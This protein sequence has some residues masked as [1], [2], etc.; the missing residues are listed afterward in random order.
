M[1]PATRAPAEGRRLRIA[2][3]L[4]ALDVGGTEN[5]TVNVINGLAGDFDHAIVTM[6][7]EGRLAA[8]LP[9]GVPVLRVVK[10]PGND[11][12][13]V[14]GLV[15]TLRALRPD[16]VHSRNWGAFDAVLAARLAGVRAVVHGE[17]GREATD[18]DGQNRRRRVLRRWLSPLISRYVTVSDDLRRWLLAQVGIAA[19]K[20]VTIPNGVDTVR[21][22]P[23]DQDGARAALGLAP[24]QR[25]V[26]TVG[27]LDPVKDQAGLI[28]AFAAVR[29]EQPGACLVIA[30]DGPCASALRALVER[31]GLGGAV[32]LLGER[33]DIPRVLAA[34]DVFVLPSIAEGMSNTVLEA[35]ATGLPVVATRVGANPE[36]V[37]DGVTGTLVPARAP[38]ALAH[39]IARYVADPLLCQLHGKASRQRV[40]AQFTLARMC[41]GYRQLY[42]DVTGAA[43]R[44][45]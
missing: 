35:M 32:V 31:L 10:R 26:G 20:V 44:T 36:L 2:H 45:A 43:A 40:E 12:R 7:G 6:A 34:L 33:H 3:V 15:R 16:V 28:E 23:P 21:F 18:P 39:A 8:R 17:H 1:A 30:G 29:R 25:I 4:H 42:L 19:H 22:A 14:L 27:R 9:A 24:S 37:D 11:P 41:A 13:V 38:A 5:G